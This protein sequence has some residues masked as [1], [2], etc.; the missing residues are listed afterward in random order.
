MLK[1]ELYSEDSLYN[2]INFLIEKEFRKIFINFC[3]FDDNER[4][5][6]I[7]GGLNKS[8]SMGEF[9]KILLHPDI[10]KESKEY[11]PFINSCFN[12]SKKVSIFGRNNRILFYCVPRKRPAVSIS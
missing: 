8:L 9:N 6:I 10:S 12:L 1:Q 5:S 7:I 2:L 4:P 11:Y 3:Y